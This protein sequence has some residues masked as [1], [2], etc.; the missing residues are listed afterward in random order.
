ML[1]GIKAMEGRLKGFEDMV[2]GFQRRNEYNVSEINSRF[3]KLEKM[4]NIHI[5]EHLE[6]EKRIKAVKEE[7]D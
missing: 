7:L 1:E 4:H 2:S 6:N 3:P 5:K